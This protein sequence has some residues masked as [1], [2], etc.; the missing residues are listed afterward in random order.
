MHAFLLAAGRGTRIS[1]DIPPIPKCTLDVGGEPLILHTIRL[2]QK[3]HMDVTV[4][5]GY[6][7]TYLEDIIKDRGA[8]IVYNPFYDV[9]NSIGSLWMAE[10]QLDCT[11]QQIIANADVYWEQDILD[12]L[13][14]AKEEAVMLSDRS[15]ADTG[16]Y[17]FQT[18]NG[19]IKAYG[20]ELTRDNRDCEYVGIASV[21]GAMA[22]CFIDSLD[23]LV[24][25]QQHGLWWENALYAISDEKPV[26][27]LD[28]EGAFW[29][30]VDTI[31]DY[32]RIM[33]YVDQEKKEIGI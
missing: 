33:M 27:A 14:S 23:N 32:R 13:L 29:A 15:R 3:N 30:E 4:I 31:E 2:L 1:K 17:F 5:T 28:V 7:H 22:Q 12:R 11:A 20:K 26:Y 21:K 8:Q 10:S 9:T 19:R 24:E 6:M 25:S 16:D 18:E